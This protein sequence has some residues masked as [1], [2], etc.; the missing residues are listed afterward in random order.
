MDGIKEGVLMGV[1]VG[2]VIRLLPG[3]CLFNALN[4][5]AT[6]V[7]YEV[8]GWI[9]CH[10]VGIPPT[11]P[12]IME[13]TSVSSDAQ[14]ASPVDVATQLT[15]IDNLIPSAP[16]PATHTSTPTQHNTPFSVRGILRGSSPDPA[17]LKQCRASPKV[18][19]KTTGFVTLILIVGGTLSAL[20][21]G[22]WGG[23]SDVNGRKRVLAVAASSEIVANTGYLL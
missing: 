10:E 6:T 1:R 16:H 18:Q 19:R 2:V 23:Y 22:F 9:A 3:H 13:S 12:T 11:N 7:S 17:W 15:T 14:S 8:I 5:W 4:G 20:T 21:S